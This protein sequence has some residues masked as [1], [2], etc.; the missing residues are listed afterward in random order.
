MR[1]DL[2]LWVSCWFLHS[3]RKKG[4][5]QSLTLLEFLEFTATMPLFFP[6]PTLPA[7]YTLPLP[8]H[9]CFGLCVRWSVPT[10]QYSPL[11]FMFESRY[12]SVQF[13]FGSICMITHS[14][15]YI[16]YLYTAIDGM[17][18]IQELSI[19]TV[20]TPNRYNLNNFD[21][22]KKGFYKNAVDLLVVLLLNT[23]QKLTKLAYQKTSGK[24]D[25]LFQQ[26]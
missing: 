22:P 18:Y 2:W 6:P 13:I 11:Q 1:L 26:Q 7:T 5:F 16:I 19:R 15:T 4:F 21:P 24:N 25:K 14:E 9:Y 12:W 10:K 8:H 17:L 3:T 20:R 23:W